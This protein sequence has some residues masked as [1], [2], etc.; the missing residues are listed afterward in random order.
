MTE[1]LLKRLKI[2]SLTITP[3]ATPMLLGFIYRKAPGWACL[4]SF[5]CS[6][7]ASAVFAFYDP[8]TVYLKSLGPW[9]DFTVSMFTI[10]LI[11]VAAFL[12]SPYIFKSEKDE[13][14]RMLGFFKKLDTPVDE[15]VE[16]PPA[17]IDRTSMARFVGFIALI[18][19]VMIVLFVFIPGTISERLTNF[20]LGAVILGSGLWLYLAGRK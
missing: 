17:E 20:G 9:M 5:A 2:S 11:G 15:A 6:A 3:L 8:L 12:V 19:G 4:F 18:L 13:Q 10:V 7:A 14:R 1:R 16:I